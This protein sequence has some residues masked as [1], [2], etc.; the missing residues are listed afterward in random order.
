MSAPKLSPEQRDSLRGLTAEFTRPGVR[1]SASEIQSRVHEAFCDALI[2]SQGTASL[3][4]IERQVRTN[5]SAFLRNLQAASGQKEYGPSD[6]LTAVPQS[7]VEFKL[8]PGTEITVFDPAK[9]TIRTG[10]YK[11]TFSYG[12]VQTVNMTL[13]V[14]RGKLGLVQTGSDAGIVTH[15]IHAYKPGTVF[16]VQAQAELGGNKV[17][18]YR[19]HFLVAA[20]S[21]TPPNCNPRKEWENIT[22]L[23]MNQDGRVAAKSD[24]NTVVTFFPVA[25][26]RR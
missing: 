6:I 26:E 1:V 12:S 9:D 22:H 10:R 16:R 3:G 4:Q 20:A 21:E 7:G 11:A 8:S 19:T 24:K 14:L 5:V 13:D 25:A 18:T 15:K 23:V 2:S 17:Q